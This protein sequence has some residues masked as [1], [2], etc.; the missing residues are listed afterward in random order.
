MREIKLT[1]G[2][3][4]LVDDKDF[5]YLN[6]FKWH[7]SNWGYAV[8]TIG[9]RGVRK[10]IFMHREIL[11]PKGVEFCDHINRNK[12]DNQRENLRIATRSQNCMNKTKSWGNS[13]KYKGVYRNKRISKWYSQIYDKNFGGIYLGSFESEKDAAEAYNLNAKRIFGEFAC[14]NVLYS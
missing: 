6:S 7:A 3:I 5:E 13:S 11:Q 2:K 12:L 10:D 9:R 8:R 1:K 4:S 14:V